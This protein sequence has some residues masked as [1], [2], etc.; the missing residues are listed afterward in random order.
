VS[1]IVETIYIFLYDP[2]I[3]AA[4]RNLRDIDALFRRQL[5]G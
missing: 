1:V 2:A 5:P 3:V 4:A